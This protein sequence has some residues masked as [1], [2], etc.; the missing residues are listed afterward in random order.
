MGKPNL[1]TCF[2]AGG[3]TFKYLDTKPLQESVTVNATRDG[4]R[5]RNKRN[6]ISHKTDAS[7][8]FSLAFEQTGMYVL[9]VEHTQKGT[10]KSGIDFHHYALYVTLE[11]FPE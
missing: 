4:T 5:H 10:K 8:L 2:L 7:G 11:V 1:T 3:C 6:T 9:E